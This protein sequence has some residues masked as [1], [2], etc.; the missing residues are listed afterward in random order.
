M[1]KLVEKP[2]HNNWTK[3]VVGCGG[4]STSW[5]VYTA[6]AVFLLGKLNSCTSF[7]LVFC[8][9]VFTPNFPFSPGIN[10]EFCTIPHPLL[11]TT[12]V[13]RI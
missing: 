1:R 4:I 10:Q 7:V 5:F 8:T 12:R 11:L 13:E 9:K 3:S 6:C 2:V